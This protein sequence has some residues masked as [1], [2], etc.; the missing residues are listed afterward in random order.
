M[1]FLNNCKIDL[2]T[3]YDDFFITISNLSSAKLVDELDASQFK[4]QIIQKD[5]AGQ[6]RRV[7]VKFGLT[8]KS[9]Y[10]HDCNFDRLLTWSKNHLEELKNTVSQISNYDYL[11]LGRTDREHTPARM[12]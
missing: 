12:D 7:V 10:F 5:G 4:V 2:E 8:G 3:I 1:S 6:A 11:I 9:R